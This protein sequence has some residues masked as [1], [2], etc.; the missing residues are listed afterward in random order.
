MSA[1]S[2]LLQ[3]TPGIP[4]RA[5]I[6]TAAFD[7]DFYTYAKSYNSSTY[8]WTG[9]LTN[10]SANTDFTGSSYNAAGTI[11][12]ETGK[13]LYP[14]ANPGITTY[15]VGVYH[16][17]L[18][19][20]FIDPNSPKFAV[21]NSDKPAYIADGVD[22][23]SSLV[24]QGQPVYTRG[25]VTAGGNITSAGSITASGQ[26]RSSTSTALTPGAGLQLDASLG[27]VFTYAVINI[28]N[29][30]TITATNNTATGS[31]VYLIIDANTSACTIT[32]GTGFRV[33]GTLATGTDATKF[34]VICF[35]SD[36]TKL[37]EISRTAAQV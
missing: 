11:I 31:L 19:N 3:A 30:Q 21:Y 18:G 14:D 35:V 16:P 33:T 13:K 26:I 34:F 5:Y 9:A 12:H 15:M 23:N 6:T 29:T 28:V 36:G 27:Q 32:F 37:C 7:A 25:T 1:T 2:A 8:T 24:D 10:S 20:G 4:K 17:V 22:P